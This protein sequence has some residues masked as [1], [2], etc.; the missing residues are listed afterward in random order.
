MLTTPAE[1]TT[2]LQQWNAAVR[3]QVV[4]A[5]LASVAWLGAPPAT[6]RD[7]QLAEAR[8]H[9]PLPPSYRAFLMVANGWR[10]ACAAVPV[11]RP[12]AQIDWFKKKN[13]D[14]ISA[15]TIIPTQEERLALPPEEIYFAYAPE[16]AMH[17]R[18]A[19][20]RCALQISDVGDAAVFLLNPQVVH[21]DGEWEAWFLAGWLPGVQRYRSFADLMFR[22]YRELIGDPVTPPDTTPIPFASLPIVYRDP[23][24]REPRRIEPRK[25]RRPLAD[26]LRIAQ[27]H[28]LRTTMSAREKAIDEIA[29]YRDS[30]TIPILRRLLH[31]PLPPVCGAAAMALGSLRAT[32]A[33][34]DLIQANAIW[35]LELIGDQPS[36]EYLLAQLESRTEYADAAARA[37]AHLH[38]SRGVAAVLAIMLDPA[39]HDHGDIAGGLAAEFGAAALDGLCAAASHPNV[40]IRGRALAGLSDL[41]CIRSAKPE[42]RRAAE[43]LAE[44]RATESDAKLRDQIEIV[45]KCMPRAA[46]S[47]GPSP[48]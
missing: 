10:Y 41:A 18:S 12:L 27:D 47:K 35:A 17:F 30:S 40:A 46:K 7:L 13:R 25:P 36:R 29:T 24:G 6:S 45:L 20:L 37:L 32:V 21:S 4:D 5:D 19:H 31:D 9:V 3:D 43:V 44:R 28:S 14:W 15:N 23:P 26:L 48:G 11:L 33:V 39:D 2:L 1:W 16:A 42:G 34:P 8:L 38:D 22:K